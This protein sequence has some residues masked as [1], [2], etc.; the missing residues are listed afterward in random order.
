MLDPRGTLR[1]R[2]T[3]SRRGDQ[4]LPATLVSTTH[5][6][7]RITSSFGPNATCLTWRIPNHTAR[8]AKLKSPKQCVPVEIL[9]GLSD[10]LGAVE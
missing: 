9:A 6:D 8:C 1:N 10:A 2:P 3:S 4:I 7:I 5:P